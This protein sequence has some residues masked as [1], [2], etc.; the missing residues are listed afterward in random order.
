MPFIRVSFSLIPSTTGY[1]KRAIFQE[2]VVKTRQKGTFVRS[3]YYLVQFL[4]FGFYFSP[5]FSGIG[6]HSKIQILEPS[7]NKNFSWAHPRTNL[8]KV[9]PAP[10][11]LYIRCIIQEFFTF[12]TVRKILTRSSGSGKPT[13]RILSSLPGRRIAG[14]MISTMIKGIC[15]LKQ[16]ILLMTQ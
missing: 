2:P 16:K 12:V 7:K 6:Y 4:C 13:N 3:G 11:S 10:G 15:K 9:P 14:S 8:G 5:I 1:Q